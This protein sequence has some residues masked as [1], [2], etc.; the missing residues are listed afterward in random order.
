MSILST[1]CLVLVAGSIFLL[2]LFLKERK[3]NHGLKARIHSMA[4]E[5]EQKSKKRSETI[6][7]KEFLYDLLGGDGIVQVTRVAP[8]DVLLRSRR[9]QE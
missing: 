2:L 1:C 4:L 7:L 8:A 5:F 9:G 6:E 3:S